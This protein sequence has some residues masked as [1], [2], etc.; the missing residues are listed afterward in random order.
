M[1]E[2]NRNRFSALSVLA[3]FTLGLLSMGMMVLVVEN[4]NTQKPPG[5][6]PP[7]AELETASEVSANPSFSRRAQSLQLAPK[8]KPSPV[9]KVAATTAPAPTPPE[10]TVPEREPSSE[11]VEETPHLPS[12]APETT[13]TLETVLSNNNPPTG[14]IIGRAFL[15]GTP[16]LEIPITVDPS[17]G[18]LIKRALTTHHFLTSET[19]ELADVFVVVTEGLHSK[20][21]PKT[22]KPAVV[23]DINCFF[24]PYVSGVRVDQEIVL[25]NSDPVLHNAHLIA[26]ENKEANFTLPP[27]HSRSIKLTAP[28]IF[29]R[30]KCDVHPWEFA[31]INVVEHPFFAVTDK[32][33]QF[34]IPPLPPGR[35]TVRAYHRKAGQLSQEVELN[36]NESRS[37]EF[38]FQVPS[39]RR[40]AIP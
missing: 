15:D 9:R 39:E 3:A 18:R 22:A 26:N 34:I 38:R 7:F 10:E 37:L 6:A 32:S 5:V 25:E 19:G 23:R 20:A 33:G 17:C 24:E 12:P 8:P 4:L 30:L 35:Y 27:K 29:V 14:S 31:Y 11:I 2:D 40:A 36:E 13:A 16:P 28:E 1:P 21:W